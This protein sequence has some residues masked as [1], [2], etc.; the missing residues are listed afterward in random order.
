MTLKAPLCTLTRRCSP[1]S[2]PVGAAP[3]SQLATGGAAGTMMFSREVSCAAA[4]QASAKEPKESNPRLQ[5]GRLV[6][7]LQEDVQHTLDLLQ[8]A[9]L[10][11]LPTITARSLN[12]FD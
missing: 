4:T 12:S 5:C 10:R 8:G 6:P 9:P 7:G 11:L 2:Q 1:H 3:T